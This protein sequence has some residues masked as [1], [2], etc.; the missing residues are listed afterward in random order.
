MTQVSFLRHNAFF[1]P[2]DV[3]DNVL[4]IIGVGATGSWVGLI[5]AKM[6]WHNFQIWD[7]DV[8]E[9]HNLPNQ[10]YSAKHIGMKKVDAFEEVL[11]DFNPQVKVTKHAR[12]FTTEEDA[13][14]FDFGAYVFIGV[15]SLAARKNIIDSIAGNPMV[16]MCAETQMGFN[17]AI[18]NYFLP[19]DF[20][21]LS[22]YKNMLKDDS[23]VQ[24]SACNERIITTLTS[25]VASTVV[26]QICSFA[27]KSRNNL[28][29]SL[30]KKQFF[31]NT[32]VMSI[33]TLPR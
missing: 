19:S 1:G 13:T 25:I 10:I 22:E 18:A 6:G 27:A 32:G 24:E 7:L 2:E 5:A 33:M 30:P 31:N 3:N 21:T 29:F 16:E 9:S 11:K 14:N 20:S 26:H 28:D 23:E 17:H 4:N 15:D 8:V 12:F